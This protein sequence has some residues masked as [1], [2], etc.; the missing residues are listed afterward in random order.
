MGW[1]SGSSGS[2]LASS[3]KEDD[4]LSSGVLLVSSRDTPWHSGLQRMMRGMAWR[5]EPLLGLLFSHRHIH[6]T[7]SRPSRS[8]GQP[9]LLPPK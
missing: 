7:S 1:C 4:S 8:S 6:V 2:S 3:E 5:K 9:G